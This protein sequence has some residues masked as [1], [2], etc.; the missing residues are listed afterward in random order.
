MNLEIINKPISESACKVLAT[1]WVYRQFSFL[2]TSEGT[3]FKLA[4][5]EKIFLSRITGLSTK[6]INNLITELVVSHIFS[7]VQPTLYLLKKDTITFKNR[8]ITIHSNYVFKLPE[9]GE[10]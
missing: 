1:I 2:E 6:R 4:G 3:V 9:K 8:E 7:R 5:P 10:R